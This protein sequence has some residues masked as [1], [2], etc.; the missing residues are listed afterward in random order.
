MKM[1][2]AIAIVG[3]FDSKADEHSTQKQTSIFL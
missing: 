2:P 1:E 3:T